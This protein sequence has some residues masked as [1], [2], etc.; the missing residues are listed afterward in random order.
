LLISLVGYGVIG[1]KEL[2]FYVIVDRDKSGVVKILEAV[3]SL[4]AGHRKVVVNDINRI[5]YFG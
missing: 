2:I 3:D 4:G 1:Y 5:V